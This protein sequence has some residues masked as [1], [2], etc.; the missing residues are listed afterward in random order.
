MI[1]RDPSAYKEEFIS[2]KR[3]FDNELEIFKRRPTSDNER[4]TDLVTFMSHIVPCY[5]KEC[6]RVPSELMGLLESNTNMLHPDVRAKLLQA[7]I[8]LRNKDLIDPLVLLKLSFKLMAVQDKTLRTMLGE[9]IFNDIKSINLNKTNEKLNKRVQAMLY[10]LV[11]E[12][13]SIVARKAVLIMCELYRRRVWTD[14]RTVNVIGKACTS[15]SIQIAVIAINFFLGIEMKMSEDEDDAEAK[16]KKELSE[17]N[18]HEHS[19]KTKREQ[20]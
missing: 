13:T 8:H 11:E 20:G 17:V 7:C 9:F 16:A 14:A 1:K 4:F 15:K 5:K 19:K 10:G 6:E 18:K 2:Q 12:D 3:R